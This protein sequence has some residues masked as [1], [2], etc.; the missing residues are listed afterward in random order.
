MK[1]TGYNTPKCKKRLERSIIEEYEW[2]S[3]LNAVNRVEAI[4]TLS[5]PVVAHSFNIVDWKTEGIRQLDRKTRKLRTLQRMHHPKADVDRMYLTNTPYL[6]RLQCSEESSTSMKHWNLRLKL[7]MSMPEKV[8][9]KQSA[10][11]KIN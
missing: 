3:E 7:Q 4:N 10:M 1:G 9:R 2:Y 5:I 6:A 8:N 11:P